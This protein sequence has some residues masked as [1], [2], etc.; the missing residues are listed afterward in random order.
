M[1][2]PFISVIVLAHERRNFIPRAL[3][4][5]E[6]QSLD[7]ALFDVIVVKPYEDYYIDSIVKRNGW[8]NIVT[9]EPHIGGKV[10]VGVEEA[11]GEIITILEDDDVYDAD[12]LKFIH[13]TFI[14]HKI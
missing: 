3:R 12:R 9:L 10:A 1:P 2:E 5:L 14:S 11:R 13:R 6:Q 7:K 8:K 4:S